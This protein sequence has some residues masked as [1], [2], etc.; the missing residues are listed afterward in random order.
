MYSKCPKMSVCKFISIFNYINLK[1]TRSELKLTLVCL[2]WPRTSSTENMLS[3]RVCLADRISANCRTHPPHITEWR[4][5]PTPHRYTVSGWVFH[6]TTIELHVVVDLKKLDHTFRTLMRNVRPDLGGGGR[7]WATA[8]A[9][10][11]RGRRC[12]I[13]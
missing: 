6:R 4:L 2:Q 1:N 5:H 7:G 10:S 12:G 9:F 3:V 8:R 11:R 13:L